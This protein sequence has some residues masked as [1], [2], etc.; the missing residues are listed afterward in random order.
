MSFQSA[1]ENDRNPY[2][3]FYDAF[4][5]FQRSQTSIEQRQSA[6]QKRIEVEFAAMDDVLKVHKTQYAEYKKLV[7]M[8]KELKAE[9]NT[10]SSGAQTP[11][12]ATDKPTPAQIASNL[13]AYSAKLTLYKDSLDRLVEIN[14]VNDSFFLRL[15]MGKVSVTMWKKSDR[16]CFK[17]EYNK[18][19]FRTT[20]LFIVFPL[21]QLVYRN[22]FIWT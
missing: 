9:T 17:D 19:K 2:T 7:R 22:T 11:I 3:L 16:M 21:I 5:Q 1:Y 4:T 20:F 6:A 8:L 13:E 15:M 10:N 18:F 14:P 12:D